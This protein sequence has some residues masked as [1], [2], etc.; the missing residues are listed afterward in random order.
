MAWL[1]ADIFSKV[2]DNFGDIGVAWRLARQLATEQELKVRLW[3][4][5][6]PSL[7]RICADAHVHADIQMVRNIEVRRWGMPF[8]EL[9]PADIVIETFGCDVPDNYVIAMAHLSRPPA[10]INFD[11]LSAEAWVDSHHGL[12][13][14]HARLPLTK[15]F[16]FPGFTEKTGGLLREKNLL[17]KRDA[18]QC[19]EHAQTKFWEKLG[20]ALPAENELRISLFCYENPALPELLQTWAE[21]TQPITCLIPQGV[22][23]ESLATFFPAEKNLASFKRG[24]LTLVSI[25]FTNQDQYDELLWACDVN[26]VR[27]EDSFVRAQWAAKPFIWHIYPQK[28]NAHWVKLHAFIDLY[29]VDMPHEQAKAT[30]DF[31]R[32]FNA[33]RGAGAAW[34]AFARD[35]PALQQHNR[36]WAAQLAA[37]TDLATGLANFCRKLIK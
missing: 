19:D 37:R 35:L 16:Y 13:S 36:L 22:A 31:W 15:Y 20:L 26:F 4:D 17:Q 24:Q 30:R 3:V 23:T 32:A 8:P 34:R 2:V 18:F 9:I 12:P 10:W 28:E 14:P 1:T 21:G 25:P 6:L 11:Y 29:S 5:H 27:G 7:A 33:G